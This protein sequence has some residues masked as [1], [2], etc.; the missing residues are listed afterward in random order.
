[1]Y[2]SSSPLLGSPGFILIRGSEQ[3]EISKD[4][5][6]ILEECILCALCFRELGGE[7][8]KSTLWS[9][10]H[11]RKMVCHVSGLLYHIRKGHGFRAASTSLLLRGQVLS[12]STATCDFLNG[13][14]WPSVSMEV[15]DFSFFVRDSEAWPSLM[16]KPMERITSVSVGVKLVVDMGCVM[17]PVCADLSQRQLSFLKL[18]I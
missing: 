16:L 14:S 3:G 13:S 11:L 10:V 17:N 6:D 5:P 4:S 18:F 7:I 1:M 15:L 2:D 9:H 8:R 12:H